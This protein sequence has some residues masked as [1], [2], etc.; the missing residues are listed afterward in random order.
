MWTDVQEHLARPR[1]DHGVYSAIATEPYLRR[2][3]HPSLLAALGVVPP[4][5]L[6]ER[7]VMRQTMEDVLAD[8]DWDS[9]WSWDFPVVAMTAARLGDA[10]TAVDALL[11][12]RS[13]NTFLANGHNPQRGNRLPLYLPGNGGL[14]AAVSLMVGGWDGA[15]R[16]APGLP[17]D[18]T[19]EVEFEGFHPWP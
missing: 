10:G 16:P 4:T 11:M 5:P 8:W 12:D 18:G 2:D 1:Q 19:W 17:D 6:I 13:K 14:L 15:D 3:D 9:V 7:E